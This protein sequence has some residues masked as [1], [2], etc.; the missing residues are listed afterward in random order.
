ME[1]LQPSAGNSFLE[2]IAIAQ[3]R[4][5]YEPGRF[6]IR[7]VVKGYL[8]RIEALDRSGLGL[9]SVIR[10]NPD[11]LQAAPAGCQSLIGL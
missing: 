7:D 9:N 10:V 1:R 6:T 8:E 3:L 11:A 4:Q 5:G 2:E